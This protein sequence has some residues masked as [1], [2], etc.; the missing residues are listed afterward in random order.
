MAP[1]DPT[2]RRQILDAG[3]RI[4]D[5]SGPEAITMRAVAGEVG[6]TPMAL[7]H[8]VRDRRDLVSGIVE[9]LL[10]DVAYPWND[11]GTW[12]ERLRCHFLQLRL[13]GHLHP[14]LAPL[15]IHH[16]RHTTAMQRIQL[17][18]LQALSDAGVPTDRLRRAQALVWT[19]QLG[20]VVR[21]AL[22]HF[23]D[24][25]PGG[26]DGDA[27]AALALIEHYVTWAVAHPDQAFPDDHDTR[28]SPYW[29][30]D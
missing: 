14:R 11:P 29:D 5:R 15:I 18:G 23:R 9:Q 28:W 24:Q 30:E 4:A 21:E 3:L 6:L 22:G 13:L 10:D 17:A 8:H 19:M 20:F 2:T 27:A 12:T 25:A 7:Y 16:N 1:T 26:A